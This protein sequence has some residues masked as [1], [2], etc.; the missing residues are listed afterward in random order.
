[1]LRWR[2]PTEDP[3]VAL[4]ELAGRNPELMSDEAGSGTLDPRLLSMDEG[5]RVEGALAVE[6]QWLEERRVIPLMTAERWF[7]FDPRLHG[8]HIRAD[9]VPLL[10][11]A[12]WGAAR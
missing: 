7:T 11:D 3:A 10:H 6:R 5:E 9:G 1:M 8:V 12:F 2:P 4:L